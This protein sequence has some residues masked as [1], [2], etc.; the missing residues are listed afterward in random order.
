[1]RRAR[2]LAIVVI[3]LLCPAAGCGESEGGAERPS[4]RDDGLRIVSLTPGITKMLVDM[5]L[6]GRIVGVAENDDAVPPRLDPPVMGHF[7]DVDLEKLAVS[8][9]THVLMMTAKEGVPANLQAMADSF[10]FTLVAYPYPESVADVASMLHDPSDRLDPP[11]LGETLDR[12]DRAAALRDSLMDGL[13]RIKHLTRGVDRPRT[14]LV[15]GEGVPVMALGP[16]GPMHDLLRIA[17][18]ENAA[19]QAGVPA[20]TFDREKLASLDPEVIIVLSPGGPPLREMDEDARLTAFRGLPVPAVEQGQIHLLND[21]LVLLPS[22][23]MLDVAA[24]LTSLL[25]AELASDVER[26]VREVRSVP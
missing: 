18:G 25:H 23:S 8:R 24:E 11:S 1:M 9:P 5:G 15:I 19:A 2:T 26:V 6:G 22:T 21:P 7:V 17:G 3:A 10:G 20:P 14:L 13:S 12:K 4:S 16:G